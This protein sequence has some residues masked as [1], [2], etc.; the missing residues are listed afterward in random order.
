[1]SK[2][3]IRELIEETIAER[4]ADI[5]CRASSKREFELTLVSGGME[6]VDFSELNRAKAQQWRV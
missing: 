4:T 1:M 5:Q 3:D 6:I 2:E